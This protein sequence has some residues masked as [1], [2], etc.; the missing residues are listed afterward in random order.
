MP[1]SF[2]PRVSRLEAEYIIGSM[3]IVILV[4]L[5]T[6]IPQPATGCPEDA[7]ICRDGTVVVRVEPNCN[8]APCPGCTCPSGYVKDGESCNPTCYYSDPPCMTPSVSCVDEKSCISDS[9]CVPE[10]CCHPTSCINR[11]FKGACNVACTLSC[12]GPLD[13]GAGS[14]GCVNNVCAIKA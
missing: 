10:Q 4:A 3:V 11:E 9:D 7:M 2:R 1:K 12:Q 8:F 13:C 14:C 5:A 6:Q